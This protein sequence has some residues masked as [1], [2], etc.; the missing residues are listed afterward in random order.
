MAGSMTA[1]DDA[2][3]LDDVVQG[4]LDDAM[5]GIFSGGQPLLDPNKFLQLQMSGRV[6]R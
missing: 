3:A 6:A 1:K 5:M 2:N 4:Q